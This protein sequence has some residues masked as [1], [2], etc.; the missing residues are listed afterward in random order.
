[1]PRALSEVRFK[2]FLQS[3]TKY[4]SWDSILQEAGIG[5]VSDKGDQYEIRC[6]LHDD[7]RPSLRL[8]KVTGVYHCFS[9][10]ASGTYTKFLWELSGRSVP[11]SEYCEQIL[12]SHPAMQEELR[13]NSLFITEKGLDPGFNQRRV[14]DRKAHLGSSMPITTLASQVR[15]VGDTWENLTFT[16]TLLQQGVATDGI[17]TLVKKHNI[18]VQEPAEKVSLMDLLD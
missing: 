4:F 9:C 7:R 10:G 11:Y 16:L 18:K 13:F 15:K 12:K 17:L 5:E 6:I 1:M 3:S 2:Q 8:N 14:F